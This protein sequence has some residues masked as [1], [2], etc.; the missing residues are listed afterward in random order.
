[1]GYTYNVNCTNCNY[2]DSIMY[3]DGFLG[4]NRI[5]YGRKGFVGRFQYYNKPFTTKP[6]TLEE[7]KLERN[8]EGLIKCPVCMEVTLKAE[9][10]LLW[11]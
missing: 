1:M 8:P 5:Y 6:K 4:T 10:F 7:L 9:F 11:D 2:Q 3:G